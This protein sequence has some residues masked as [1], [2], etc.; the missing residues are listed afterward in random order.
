[1]SAP[2]AAEDLRPDDSKPDFCF[3]DSRFEDS[4]DRRVG[5]PALDPL[6]GRLPDPPKR[7]ELPGVSVRGV[8]SLGERPDA[9]S[10]DP[11]FCRG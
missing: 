3:E 1:M 10:F 9:E 2:A 11:R 5:L 7:R 4:R 8:F 6:V